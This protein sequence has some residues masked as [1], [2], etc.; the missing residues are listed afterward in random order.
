MIRLQAKR[1][2]WKIKEEPW[3]A[4]RVACMGWDVL[5]LL[6]VDLPVLNVQKGRADYLLDVTD[7]AQIKT[8][9]TR[10]VRF[11]ER[12]DVVGLIAEQESW[13]WFSNRPPLA[14]Y[15]DSFAELTDQL[16]IHR[17]D[18]WQFCCNYSDLRH[19]PK[20]ESQFET[21]GLLPVTDLLMLYRRFFGMVRQRWGNIPVVFLHFPTVLDKREKFQ[22]RYEYIRESITQVA[23]EFPPF[24]SLAVDNSVVD[25]PEVKTPGLEGFPYHY[26]Q[27]TYQVLA[28]QVRATAV[29]ETLKLK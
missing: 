11:M 9:A 5:K 24:H 19:G 6:R 12:R 25:W 27:R 13:D 29:F 28:E 4:G 10:V 3:L 26:N 21:A 23:Q 17:R 14:L 20:F 22:L 15:M 16:F 2:Q 8:R 18:K 7:N 1:Q